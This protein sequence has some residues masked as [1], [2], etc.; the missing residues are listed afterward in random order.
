MTV[1]TMRAATLTLLTRTREIGMNDRC[2]L[3]VVLNWQPPSGE[4]QP[5]LL[6]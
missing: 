4:A 5:H 1:S 2:E 3:P 6:G